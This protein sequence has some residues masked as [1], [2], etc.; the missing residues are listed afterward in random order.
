MFFSAI[1]FQGEW[2]ECERRD[3]RAIAKCA[4][5]SGL[6]GPRDEEIDNATSHGSDKTRYCRPGRRYAISF[7]RAHF[8]ALS[9]EYRVKLNKYT[10]FVISDAYFLSLTPKIAK[11]VL[12]IYPT[13]KSQNG[14]LDLWR[15]SIS[16]FIARRFIT[17]SETVGRSRSTFLCASPLSFECLLNSLSSSIDVEHASE[18]RLLDRVPLL[19][20]LRLFFV[21]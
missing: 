14:R 7:P 10:Y 21:D 8:V 18:P 2:Q 16:R 15:R 20:A 6:C 19:S 1:I 4:S 9:G 17:H 12:Q 13:P 3:D 5:E 11:A